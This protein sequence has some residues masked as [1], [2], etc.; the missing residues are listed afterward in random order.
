MKPK[1]IAF[2]STK[3][4]VGKSSLAVAVAGIAASEHNMKVLLVDADE[5][6]GSS[7]WFELGGNYA[8][9][10]TELADGTD[11]KLA[12][13]REA[14]QYDL[15][16]VDLPGFRGQSLVEVIVGSAYDLLVL[17]TRANPL[18][19]APLRP[20]I[21]AVEGDYRVVFTIT[22]PGHDPDVDA[23]RTAFA[24][25][26]WNIARTTVRQSKGW[27][28]AAQEARLVTAGSGF[29]AARTDA[30]ALTTELIDTI[31]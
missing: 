12:H 17:P 30:R 24:T 25:V 1:I 7:N 28:R 20:L 5:N 31:A 14:K 4:G 19:I 11:G 9:Y 29:P 10:D 13:L 16:V 22:T 2:A 26:G 27:P 21:P 6:R 23:Y 15:I 8:P 3:G 18:D